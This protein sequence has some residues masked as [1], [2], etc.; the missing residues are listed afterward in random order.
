MDDFGSFQYNHVIVAHLS[1]FVI[2][3]VV[4]VKDLLKSRQFTE[5]CLSVELS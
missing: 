3:Q 5:G 4:D 1:L 2:L